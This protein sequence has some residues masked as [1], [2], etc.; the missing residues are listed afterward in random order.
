[1]LRRLKQELYYY[2]VFTTWMTL[3]GI[4]K[5]R[6]KYQKKYL[7]LPVCT[8]MGRFILFEAPHAGN[9]QLNV[10]QELHI[11]DNCYID[12]SGG[13]TLGNGVTIS[14]RASIFTHEHTLSGRGSWRENPI[15]YIPI[16]ICDDAWIGAEAK[17]MPSVKRI[18]LGAVIGSGAI[19]TKDVAD[20]E[21]VGGNPAQKI[22]SRKE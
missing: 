8:K 6:V 11:S 13:V 21:I 9:K 17:I 20:F 1:M 15:K 2:S 14:E 5:V 10:G 7:G 16:E 18:G 12:F 19:V 3:P 22:G 4:R